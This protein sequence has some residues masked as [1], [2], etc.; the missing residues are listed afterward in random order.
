MNWNILLYI[1]YTIWVFIGWSVVKYLKR[2]LKPSIVWGLGALLLFL[3]LLV[4]RWQGN[5][6]GTNAPINLV[7]YP[8]LIL[9]LLS[10]YDGISHYV[11]RLLE[12]KKNP[13]GRNSP[14]H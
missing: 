4:F 3:H 6:L 10:C 7:L 2:V 5:W 13:E 14:T 9:G 1:Y 8:T 11:S 12:K